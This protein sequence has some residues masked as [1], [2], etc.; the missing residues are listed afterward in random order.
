M[1]RALLITGVVLVVG[2]LLWQGITSRGNPDPTVAT[3]S[4]LAAVVDTAVLVFREGLESILVLAAVT[5][6]LARTRPGYWKPVGSGAGIGFLA[7]LVTWFVVVG[8]ISLV[9]NTTSELSLQPATG[10]L[11]VI[12]LLVIMNWFFRKVY[13]QGWIG[14]HSRRSREIAGAAAGGGH[15][16]RGRPGLPRPRGARLRLGLPRGL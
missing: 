10:L 14:H 3:L 16:G 4:P 15:L 11:A 12:V 1:L 8:I 6:S 9:A 13:W 5:A 7:T 2:L